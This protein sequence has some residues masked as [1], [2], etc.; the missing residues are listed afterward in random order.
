MTQP[1]TIT[2]TKD[3]K[4]KKHPASILVTDKKVKKCRNITLNLYDKTLYLTSKLEIHYSENKNTLCLKT[5]HIANP[6][7]VYEFFHSNKQD[8]SLKRR[9]CSRCQITYWDWISHRESA[10][11]ISN[12]NNDKEDPKQ[13]Q[14]SLRDTKEWIVI[15]TIT[16]PC[17]I[18][19]NYLFK[20]KLYFLSL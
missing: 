3:T 7:F 20:L 9:N 13:Q 5:S 14:K 11:H 15:Q 10:L 6:A 8:K 1:T 4:Y 17:T 2:F 16:M 18:F 12:H 19:Q